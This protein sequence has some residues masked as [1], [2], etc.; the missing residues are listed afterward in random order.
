[1]LDDGMRRLL[2]NYLYMTALNILA[3]DLR[4]TLVWYRVRGQVNIRSKIT[5]IWCTYVHTYAEIN[6]IIIKIVYNETG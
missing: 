3:Q 5:N 4:T 1:M 2:Y 6:K